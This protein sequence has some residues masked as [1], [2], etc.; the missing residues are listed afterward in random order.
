MANDEQQEL[1]S[2]SGLYAS[3]VATTPQRRERRRKQA[4]VGIAG[5]AAVLA[6]AGFLATQLMSEE[7]PS[8]PE[9]AAMAPLTASAPAS[10]PAEPSAEPSV[11]RTSKSP[12][13]AKP[14]ELSPA[15]TV[16][17]TPDAAPTPTSTASPT[18]GSQLSVQSQD[19]V[20]ERTEALAN[21]TI[22]IVSARSDLSG[23]RELALAG[24]QGK[25]VGDGV[26]CTNEVRIAS[27]LP[28]GQR[29]TMLLCW[30]TSKARSVVTMAMVPKGDAPT[31]KSVDIIGKE[32]AKL[33]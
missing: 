13:A 24:D 16:S 29:P 19:G 32:W 1:V 17:R 4:V 7:Q 18:Q 12:K 2:E 5:A 3:A 21:G 15:P 33:G 11:T 31:A 14:V 23:Q 30:R 20:T 27:G 8:L 25:S 22:R 10:T 9:P 26:R 6:G 28:A